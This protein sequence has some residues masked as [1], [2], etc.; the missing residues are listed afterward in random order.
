MY[1]LGLNGSG[2]LTFACVLKNGELTVMAEEKRF[3]YKVCKM[4]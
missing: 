2:V 1:V 4:A 3:I